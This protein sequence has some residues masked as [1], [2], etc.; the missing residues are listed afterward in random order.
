MHELAPRAPGRHGIEAALHEV[1]D[2]LDVVVRLALDALDLGG[3]RVGKLGRERIEHGDRR[4]GQAAQLGDARLAGERLEP[5]RL[6]PHA[7][8][9]QAALA[10]QRAQL[11]S[12]VGVAAVD[13]RNRVQCG[14]SLHA[15]IIPYMPIDVLRRHVNH[16]T[17]SVRGVA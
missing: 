2:R 6:D 9:D 7:L 12:L 11:R 16:A 17:G 3:F 10:E 4:R 14:C 13:R 15:R 1:F 8:A 5:Q